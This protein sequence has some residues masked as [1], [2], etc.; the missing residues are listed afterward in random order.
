[1][2]DGHDAVHLRRFVR[3]AGGERRA[4]RRRPDLQVTMHRQF[5]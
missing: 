2:A 3:E 1:M 5:A 4:L